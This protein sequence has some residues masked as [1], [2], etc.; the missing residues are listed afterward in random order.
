MIKVERLESQINSQK[1]FGTKKAKNPKQDSQNPKQDSQN[2]KQ[3]RQNPKRI[4]NRIATNPK[5]DSHKS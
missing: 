3:D 2:P 1:V 4:L 5:Q